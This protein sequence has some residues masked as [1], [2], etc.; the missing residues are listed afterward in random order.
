M[1]KS[2]PR[3]FLRPPFRR[4]ILTAG[5]FILVYILLIFFQGG[6]TA[7]SDLILLD[8]FLGF[9]SFFFWLLFF[10]QFTL[11]LKH[12]LERREAFVRLLYYIV[13]RNGAAVRIENGEIKERKGES[14]RNGPGVVLLDTASAAVIRDPAQFKGPVGPGVYFTKKHESIAGTVDLH[15]QTD[16]LGPTENEDPFAPQAQDESEAAYKARQTRR[17]ATQGLTRDGIAVA[18]RINVLVR[19]DTDQNQGNTRFGY[20]PLAVERAIKGMPVDLGAANDAPTKLVNLTWLPLHIAADIFKEAISRYTLEDLF[21]YEPGKVTALQLILDHMRARMTKPQYQDFDTFGRSNSSQ[22][23]SK[24]YEMLKNRGVRVIS[25]S[26]SFLK[27]PQNVENRLVEMWK[28]TWLLRAQQER[29]Y[30]DYLRGYETERGK[31]SAAGLYARGAT[32]YL[33]TQNP[34]LQLTGEQ[35][36]RQLIRGT[37]YLSNQEY[38]LHSQAVDEMEQLKELL[39]WSEQRSE[40]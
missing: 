10:S 13:G 30:V 31:R 20:N 22:Q 40:T 26:I 8:M 32:H 36:L 17:F 28:S 29:K 4:P 9:I 14:S 3:R 27:F 16:V 6:F 11:P 23:N 1:K 7:K 35:V 5:F 24:E 12:I 33:G 34:S 15:L 18:P 25:A 37:L 21:S 2:S 38:S 19:L 39:E